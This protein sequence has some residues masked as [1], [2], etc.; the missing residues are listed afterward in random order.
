M[1]LLEEA[2]K[3]TD[4]WQLTYSY[5]YIPTQTIIW[6][7]DSMYLNSARY[8]ASDNHALIK[9]NRTRIFV[10]IIIENR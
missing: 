7:R 3:N 2:H 1:H 5:R 4:K 10:L 8:Y 6:S 9:I